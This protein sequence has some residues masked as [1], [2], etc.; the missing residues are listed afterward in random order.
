MRTCPRVLQ[1]G[2]SVERVMQN[3]LKRKAVKEEGEK[4]EEE[5]EE[6]ELKEEEKECPKKEP[7][8]VE[9]TPPGAVKSEPESE[10]AQPPPPKK[11]RCTVS[12]KAEPGSGPPL[13]QRFLRLLLARLWDASWEVRHGAAT[14]LRE[15]LRCHQMATHCGPSALENTA[16]RVLCTL[17][18][19]QVSDFISDDVVAP[20][21]ET[22]AQVLGVLCL[23]LEEAQIVRLVRLLLQL[24]SNYAQWM[25][26]QGGLLGIKYVL[27]ATRASMNAELL[28][29]VYHDIFH[30]LV[31]SHDDDVL[32]WSA[33]TL[34]PVTGHLAEVLPAAE[35]AELVGAAWALVARLVGRHEGLLSS[36]AINNLMGLLC[37]LYSTP[38]VRDTV[39][40]RRASGE[41][42]FS[43]EGCL[44]LLIPYLYHGLESVRVSTVRTISILLRE[45]LK[46]VKEEQVRVLECFTS[47]RRV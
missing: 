24:C 33:S 21:R 8:E 19:D 27:A 18:L 7:E 47:L 41:A 30:H 28:P 43:L 20:V 35:V 46:A 12:P 42:E 17:S 45:E 25:V 1:A 34:C 32:A 11:Q 9:G 37:A 31:H 3:A 13:L 4:K 16:V 26:A 14:G 2:R 40:N 29:L 44:T 38:R 6:E 39:A 5:K 10:G 36:C 22:C 15:L 23:H